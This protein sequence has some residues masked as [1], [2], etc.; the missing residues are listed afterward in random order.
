VTPQETLTVEGDVFAARAAGR[1][2]FPLAL[3][4]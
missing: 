3:R 4:V 1:M 2:E